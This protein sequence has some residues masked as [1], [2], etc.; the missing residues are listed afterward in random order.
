MKHTSLVTKRIISIVFLWLCVLWSF[1]VAA[2]QSL[3]IDPYKNINQ[4]VFSFNQSLDDNIARPIAQLYTKVTPDFIERGV[5]NMFDNLDEI[6]NVFND[7]LQ[8]KF[9]QAANDT[10]RF[11]INSSL[12]VAGLFDVASWLSLKKNDG[13]D[14]GQTL[15]YW[16]VPEGAYLMLPLV[17]P[18]SLRDAPSR[19][20]DRI[21]DPLKYIDDSADRMAG[22]ALS[23]VNT[24]ASLLEYD[25][26]LSG[27]SYTLV[28]DVYLQRRAY[29]VKDGAVEDEF[30][31]LDDY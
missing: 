30:D 8:G 10:G 12:G 1:A 11:A 13:E 27:D 4:K 28:R 7:L 15:G 26:L 23:L 20:V 2:D 31:D 29:Q 21:T 6:T 18:S 22:S 16:G 24:R 14:F 17:G 25:N 19:I 5:A 3:E 9:L